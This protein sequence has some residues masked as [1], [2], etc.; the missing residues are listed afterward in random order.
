M[1]INNLNSTITSMTNGSTTVTSHVPG[2]LS[3]GQLTASTIYASQATGYSFH[4]AYD[5]NAP[6]IKFC[7]NT[8]EIVRLERDGTVIWGDTIDIDAA[9]ESFSK[10]LTMGSE[11]AAGI[12]YA[13]KLR[14]RDTVF[15]EIISIAKSKGPL[16]VEDLTYLLQSSKIVEK[17]KGRGE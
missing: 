11:L 17:L 5:V 4:G 10:S 15:E 8:N 14:M 6:V 16:S 2:V 1:P 12:T 7:D 3:A 13:T 9:A